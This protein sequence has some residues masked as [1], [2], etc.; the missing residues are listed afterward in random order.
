MKIF[1]KNMVCPRCILVIKMELELLSIDYNNVD[2]GEVDLVNELNEFQRQ[3]FEGA[4]NKLGFEI[5]SDKKRLIIEQ[6]KI[7]IV[8]LIHENEGNIRVNLSDY[9]SSQFELDYHFLTSLF[10][11]IEGYTIEHFFISQKIEKV[12]ELLAYNELTL[13]EIAYKLNYS[14]VAHL[15]N[16]FKKTTHFSPSEFKKMETNNRKSIGIV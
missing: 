1:I 10:S 3:K 8:R 5:L 16:Q 11:E 9:L 4:L 2:F 14:S 12:K 6:I 7:L 13:S 15:S